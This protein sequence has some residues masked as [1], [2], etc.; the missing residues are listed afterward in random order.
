MVRSHVDNLHGES[1]TVYKATEDVAAGELIGSKIEEVTIP[2]GI[3][4]SLL[5]DAPTSEL[6]DLIQTTELRESVKAGELLMFRHFDSSADDGVV[7]E[8]P[9]GKK[10]ISIAVNEASSVSYFIKPGDMVDVLATFMGAE[11]DGQPQQNEEMFKV[12]TR[13][14]VQAARVLAVGDDYRQSDRQRRE[15][16]SSVTLLVSMEEAAKLVFARDFFGVNM[17]LVLRGENDIGVDEILPEVGIST[18]N[19]DSIGN[20]PA[21][22]PAN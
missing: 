6:L 17:T 3:F 16:Y 7:P 8:I 22:N 13:P 21:V 18:L 15:P 2:A 14:I 9:P 5:K 19:F 20:S 12:S 1:I 10:A 4:P 11:A